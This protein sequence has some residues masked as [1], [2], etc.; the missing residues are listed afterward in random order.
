[1]PEPWSANISLCT[2]HLAFVDTPAPRGGIKVI[3]AEPVL[4]VVKQLRNALDYA[5]EQEVGGR[6]DW[7]DDQHVLDALEAGRHLLVANGGV[8]YAKQ[9]MSK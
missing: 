7:C 9:Q 8:A 4:A 2:D 1:M 5:R 6:H 3:E